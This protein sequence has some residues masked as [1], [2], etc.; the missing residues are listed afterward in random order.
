MFKGYKKMI[1]NKL[2]NHLLNSIIII[3]FLLSG[4]TLA[5]EDLPKLV[6]KIQPAVVTIITYDGRGKEKSIG[7]GFFINSEGHFLTNYHVLKDAIRV[8]IKTHEG[9]SYTMKRVI[10]Q[11]KIGDLAIGEVKSP[12][13]CPNLS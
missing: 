12:G 4:Q 3:F 7:T 9:L 2:T 6:K 8:E 5:L 11:D 10:S 1:I 13:A